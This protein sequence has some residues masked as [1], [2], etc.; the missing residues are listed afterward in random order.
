MIVMS[1]TRPPC[2]PGLIVC[3]EILGLLF[4][5]QPKR[6]KPRRVSVLAGPSRP[7]WPHPRFSPQFTTISGNQT[8]MASSHSRSSSEPGS[9]FLTNPS[10]DLY[11][12]LLFMHRFKIDIQ[13][14]RR[15][16]WQFPSTDPSSPQSAPPPWTTKSRLLRWLRPQG[17][18]RATLVLTRSILPLL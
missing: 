18:I 2:N 7:R 5:V 1:R 17:L 12:D 9:W 4:S 13:S 10:A 16:T 15:F 3:R 6:R 8:S 11:K 14:H